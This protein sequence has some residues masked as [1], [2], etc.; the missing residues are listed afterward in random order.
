MNAV[1]TVE[2]RRH[3]WVALSVAVVC[4]A[5]ILWAV[6]L[7]RGGYATR[8]PAVPISLAT[9]VA[10]Q[11][12][13][14]RVRWNRDR[15]LGPGNIAAMLFA[16]QL[17]VIPTLLVLSGPYPGTLSVIPADQYVNTALMLQALAY[18]CYAVGYVAWTK[19]VRPKT[20]SARTGAYNGNCGLSSSRSARWGLRWRFRPLA[21]SSPTSAG[22][23]T[24]SMWARPPWAARHRRSCAR[25]CHMA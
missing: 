15:V 11:L 5:A 18:A 4:V 21:H 8:Y 3:P 9:F 1:K 7:Q 16:I 25:S 14:P 24:S 12:L 2:V 17:V 19:P 10:I 20:P 23:A 13:V 22:R 6:A